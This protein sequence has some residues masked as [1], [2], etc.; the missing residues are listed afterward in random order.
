MHCKKFNSEHN[1]IKVQI[2]ITFIILTF[3]TYYLYPYKVLKRYFMM[4][5]QLYLFHYFYLFI[6]TD[7]IAGLPYLV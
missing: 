3:Y 4:L 1:N 7:H 2:Y 5:T 6:K